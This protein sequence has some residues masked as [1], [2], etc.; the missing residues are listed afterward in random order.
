MRVLMICDDYYHPASVV[1][2]GLDRLQGYEF[3]Y[4][5]DAGEWS[6]EKMA[7]YPVV[8]FAKSNN[9]TAQNRDP[10]VTPEV[11]QAF[12]DY[13]RSGRGLLAVHSGTVYK[14]MET[15]RALLGGVF[16]FHPRQC[17]VTVQ[18]VA[19]HPLTQGVAPFT[20]T[21]EH[22]HMI[23]DDTAADVFATTVSE[24]SEQPG[25]WTRTEGKGRVGVLT[26]GHTVEAFTHPSF[27]RLVTNCL[28]WCAGD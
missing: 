20:V 23:M 6:P 27:L 17:P 5:E 1:H 11:Q 9:I 8:L 15:M 19:G 18:P 24:H 12:V 22:Y 16:D 10:W 21:D 3:D 26:P 28:A 4:I 25:G 2:A 13:V 7:E 14:D